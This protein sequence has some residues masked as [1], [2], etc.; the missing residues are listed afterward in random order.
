MSDRDEQ[1][2]RLNAVVRGVMT[3][4]GKSIGAVFYE[5]GARIPDPPRPSLPVV[6]N[7]ARQAYLYEAGDA[8]TNAKFEAGLAAAFKV[9]LRDTV[10][11]L[12]SP[13]LSG[14]SWSIEPLRACSISEAALAGLIHALTGEAT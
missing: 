4:E 2:R 7:E 9:I 6:G 3:L 11:A 12:K 10:A 14:L 13:G 1:V 8:S 5:A